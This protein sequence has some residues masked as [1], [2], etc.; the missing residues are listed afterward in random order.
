M[1]YIQT[2]AG[3]GGGEGEVEVE[4]GA[5]EGKVPRQREMRCVGRRR[6]RGERKKSTKS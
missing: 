5:A 4:G 1:E 6:W 2:E 3:A